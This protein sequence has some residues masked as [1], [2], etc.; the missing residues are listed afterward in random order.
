MCVFQAN[1][2]ACI[3]LYYINQIYREGQLLGKLYSY[4]ERFCKH[5]VIVST[6][7]PENHCE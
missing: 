6:T 4:D 1:I 7:G 2:F 3:V 5:C